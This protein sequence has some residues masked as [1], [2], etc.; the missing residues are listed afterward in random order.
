MRVQNNANIATFTTLNVPYLN[1]EVQGACCCNGFAVEV[2]GFVVYAASNRSSIVS[3]S[4]D[5]LELAV[6]VVASCKSC[7]QSVEPASFCPPASISGPEC[8]VHA[9]GFPN[10]PHD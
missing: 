4:F 10:L 6:Y 3:M 1:C 2:N 8:V 5:D 9:F 7:W